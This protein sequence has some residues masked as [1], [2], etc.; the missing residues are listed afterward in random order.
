MPRD[1]TNDRIKLRNDPDTELWD[2]N[3]KITMIKVLK[4]LVE[5]VGSLHKQLDNFSCNG[6]ARNKSN[7]MPTAMKN[8]FLW[9]H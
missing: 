5:R 7:M 9:T 8:T 6:N 2:R 3:F 1:E 4:E